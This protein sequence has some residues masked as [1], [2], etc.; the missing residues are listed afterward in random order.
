VRRASEHQELE[1]LP[2]I[3]HQQRRLTAGQLRITREERA[4]RDQMRALL[5]HVGV[6]QVEC[7]GFV[8][9]TARG[10]DGRSTVKV[11]PITRDT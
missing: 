10:R 4:L 5:D 2:G 1:T 8:I 7:N 11:T 9:R 3:L 6:D